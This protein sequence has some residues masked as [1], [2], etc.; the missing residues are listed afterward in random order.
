MC[1]LV[2]YAGSA[3]SPAPLV[4]GGAHSLWRQSFRPRELLTGSVNADG[5]GVVWYSEGGPVR[6]ASPYPIWRDE[7]LEGLLAS[8]RAPIAVAAL[9]NIT[10]GIPPSETAIPPLVLDEWAFVLNGYIQDFRSRFMRRVHGMIPDALFA[11][12]TGVSDTEALFL[13]A[14]AAANRAHGPASALAA[15]V[16]DVTGLARQE[17][18]AAQLNM[19]LTDG[20]RL[21]ACR[22][23]AD[24]APNSLYVSERGPMA[25]DGVIVA[26]EPLCADGDWVEVPPQTV[27]EVSGEGVRTFD[28]GG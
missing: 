1:R 13:L 27:I 11:R 14:V 24:R 9:R 2:A 17:G 28:L 10:S 18:A 23:A 12:L 5:Y 25:P 6:V 3:I 4:F 21:A 8:V 22:V 19:V 16:Q 7:D 20:R 15:L 26:S